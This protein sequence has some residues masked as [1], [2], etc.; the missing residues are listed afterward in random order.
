MNHAHNLIGRT[1]FVAGLTAVSGI[2][3]APVVFS[4][5]GAAAQTAFDEF[6]AAIGGAANRSRIGWD[7]VGLNGTDANPATRTIDPGTVEIPVDRFRAAGAI[8]AEPYAVSGDGFA[9]VNPATAGQFPAF[10]PAN[11]FVMFD[12]TPGQFEERTIEQTF[13]LNGTDTPAATRGFGAIFVDVELAGSSIEYR[14][15]DAAGN[16]VSLGTFDVETGASTDP[17]FLGVVFGGPIVTEVILT[18][19]TNALFSFDGTNFQSFGPEDLAAGIDLAATDDFL[20]ATPE[21]IQAVAV[22][23]PATLAL[24]L[25]ASLLYLLRRRASASGS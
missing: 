21:P 8:F 18:V 13:V 4:G 14:G 25:P 1:V 16:P 22:P 7:G 19:G 12:S 17:Q 3:A 24:L 15:V 10:S 20:F 5:S 9:G 2:Q 11:T 6:T 23:V